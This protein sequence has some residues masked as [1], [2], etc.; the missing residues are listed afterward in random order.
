MAILINPATGEV[1]LSDSPEGAIQQGLRI[2]TDEEADAFATKLDFGTVGAQLQAQGERV[3]RGA[4][5]GAVEGFGEPEDIRVRAEVSEELS[6]VTSFAAT[7]VPDIA[8]GALTGGFG[9]LATGAGRAAAGTALRSG[10]GLARAGLAAGRAGGAAALAGESLGV[11]AVA[12][13]QEAYTEERSAVDDPG[14]FAEDVLFWGGLNFGLGKLLGAGRRAPEGNAVSRETAEAATDELDD[15]AQAAEYEAAGSAAPPAPAAPAPAGGSIEDLSRQFNEMTGLSPKQAAGGAALGAAGVLG[16]EGDGEGAALAG[17]GGLA[18]LGGRLFAKSA[19]RYAPEAERAARTM[20]V[21]KKLSDLHPLDNLKPETLDWLRQS[22]EFRSTGNIASDNFASSEGGLPNFVIEGGKVHLTNGRHRFTVAREQGMPSIE[23]VIRKF[24]PRGGE[25]WRYQGPIRITRETSEEVSSRAVDV[26]PTIGLAGPKDAL[27]GAGEFEP[28]PG[29]PATRPALDDAPGDLPPIPTD[30]V[31]HA[32]SIPQT[33]I[34]S[35][36][37]SGPIG[38]TPG[39]FF[40]GDDGIIRYV[41]IDK[42]PKHTSREIANA[43]MYQALGIRTPDLQAVELPGGKRAVTSE[44]LG[45]QWRELD[46]VEDWA[47]LPQ[48][49]RDGYAA[50]VPID[51][52]LGNWDVSRNA[53]NVMT[54]GTSTLMVDAG[55]AGVNAWGAK[56]FRGNY[57]HTSTEI[58]RTA[59][60]GKGTVPH[61]LDS[62]VVDPNWGPFVGNA[63]PHALLSDYAPNPGQLRSIVQQSYDAA[64]AK[65]EAAGG[66][67]GFIRQHVPDL[68]EAELERAASEMTVRIRALD[69]AVPTL[70]A[71]SYA[72]T[73]GTEA[74][75]SD[76]AAAAGIGALAMLL[77]R[78]GLMGA[79]RANPGARA[80]ARQA[81]TNA[82]E[83]G[84]ARALRNASKTNADDIVARATRGVETEADSLGRQ[85]RLYMNRGPILEVAAR[86]MQQDLTQV[87]KDVQQ[88]TRVEKLAA[89]ATHVSDNI[90]AQKS[91]ARVISEDA[92]KFA[93]ELRGEVRAYAAAS[94]KKGLQY[95]ITGQKA[96]TLALIDHAKQV[97]EATTGKA[98]FEA[99]DGFKRAAQDFKL[100]L[101]AGA[102]NSDNPIHHQALIPRIEAFARQIRTTLEDSGTWGRAGD[103]QRSYN[104][105]IHD[106]LVPSMRV[107]EE[108]VLKRT[109]RGYDGL[110]NTEGWESKIAGLLRNKDPGERRHVAAVLDGMDE[111]ASVRRQYGDAK[112]ADRIEERTAKVRRTMGLAD[113]VEDASERM[114]AI[115]EVVGAVPL[116]GMIR[117]FVT[118]D[119]FAAYQRLAGASEEAIG[120]GVD[121]W[122]RSSRLRGRGVRLP[123]VLESDEARQL[124]ELAKRRG[125]SQTMVLFQGDDDSPGAAFERW[126]DAM[127]DDEKFFDELGQD[128]DTLNRSEPDAFLM[129]SGRADLARQFL[130]QRMPPNVAVSMAQPNGYPPSRESVEDWA[131]YV[132]AVRDPRR[133]IA[134][135]GAMSQPQVEAL[136]T[137]YPRRHEQ[138]QQRVIEA[139]ATANERGEPLD[140]TFMVR[141]GLLFPDVD[142]V[143]SPVF[144]REYGNAVREY[145]QGQQQAQQQRSGRPGKAPT[146]PLNAT[147]QGGATFG[148]GF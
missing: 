36:R 89:V 61:S 3:L 23:G 129:L 134:N 82:A 103:M 8:V 12:A 86:E 6:P 148:H 106:K 18:L 26:E 68:S 91:A 78:G 64:K 49:V 56:W 25:L 137:V 98:L 43:R 44:Y 117:G 66:P 69:V 136:R 113:E 24:G 55:E 95:A 141:A 85:R 102:L 120:R 77:G 74:D 75:A 48:S 138:L 35:E 54:D 94:G 34:F 51:I 9:G 108:A 59:Q 53:R 70:A 99:L 122:I 33:G 40:R 10:A 93:G 97:G 81:A 16:A 17:A 132:V 100:S 123:K 13:G 19:K 92:A 79:R 139:I 22:D 126:R 2:A 20:L 105:V 4:T 101:E 37:L 84:M 142:G 130:I 96:W 131:E 140:D 144:S 112:T 15:I 135:V 63:P 46:K 133:V 87:A 109:H 125:I 111:L 42:D 71:L 65:I 7:L 116:G 32:E 29:V 11:G 119:V 121:D 90:A 67:E 30:D 39:G 115:G 110:W 73:T 21:D 14:K 60:A 50:Q 47:T 128:Y 27:R 147:I 52:L 146:N 28:A 1:V 31:F 80:A 104:A 38:K 57:P 76:P 5:L 143:G 62:A 45:S 118:G 124:S 41:K 83:D 127:L 58:Q 88:V 107:F 114:Q 145:N 72:Q